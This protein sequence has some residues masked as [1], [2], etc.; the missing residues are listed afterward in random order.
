MYYSATLNNV[1]ELYEQKSL[2]HIMVL[3]VMFPLDFYIISEIWL[4]FAKYS[5]EYKF[6]KKNQFLKINAPNLI[7]NLSHVDYAIFN[8]IGSLTKN[9]KNLSLLYFKERGMIYEFSD[10]ASFLEKFWLSSHN[11]NCLKSISNCFDANMLYPSFAQSK[12]IDSKALIDEYN[13]NEGFNL[14]NGLLESVVLTNSISC[15]YAKHQKIRK[16]KFRLKEEKIM[17]S[18]AKHLEYEFL[19]YYKK[20]GCLYYS[21]RVKKHVYDYKILGFHEQ[22]CDMMYNLFTIIYEDPRKNNFVISCKGHASKLIKRLRFSK[23]DFENLDSILMNFNKKGF[24]DPLMYARRILS[25]EEANDFFEK[26]NILQQSLISQEDYL[27]DLVNELLIDLE[28]MGLAGLQDDLEPDSLELIKFLKSL[29]INSW[30]LTGDN[31]QSAYNVVTRI[32]MFDEDA[33]QFCIESENYDDLVKQVKLILGSLNNSIKPNSQISFASRNLK[34]KRAI[35]KE[36]VHLTTIF[37]EKFDKYMLINGKS[38][39]H[40][41]K[42]EYLFSN[43]L[44]ACSL[45]RTVVGFNFTA[46]NKKQFV[47]IIKHKF[48]RKFT[49]MA[50]GHGFND[51][52]MMN[53][54]DIGIEI[55]KPSKN[56]LNVEINMMLGDIVLTNL[57][58]V[59]QLM[60]NQTGAYF[61]RFKHFI[62]LTYFKSFLYGYSLFFY[63]FF[64]QFS[65]NCFYDS[66][67]TVLYFGFLNVPSQVLVLVFYKK[68]PNKIRDELPEIYH[69]SKYQKKVMKIIKNLFLLIVEG[70][71]ISVAINLM[72]LLSV[73]EIITPDGGYAFN[74]NSL[75]FIFVY[76][77]SIFVHAK[78]EY[79]LLLL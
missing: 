55:A 20:E 76:S 11:Q 16:L 6:K 64:T 65:S 8:K 30:I 58:Q 77:F 24:Q 53:S 78:V 33:E 71:I 32:G 37:D 7:T 56:H 13:S 3:T 51:I 62:E 41:Q 10:Y 48:S 54:A 19:N 12:I 31:K 27:A 57:R 63:A 38:F 74:Y 25:Q 34:S 22:E 67:M 72:T 40:I 9:S 68:F 60:M 15:E 44:F 36:S 47:E 28:L 46:K 2:H 5:L 35:A 1:L 39:D 45:L 17:N 43:F 23:Q 50:I 52:L 29:S 4:L 42:D 79:S 59:K 26:Y 73:A 18:F 21:V 61:D 14:F 69:E 70:Y 66:L 75:G 49:V